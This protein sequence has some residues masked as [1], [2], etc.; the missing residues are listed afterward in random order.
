MSSYADAAKVL[1]MTPAAV[2]QQVR[3]L[4]QFFE[5]KLLQKHGRGVLLTDH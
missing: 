4:E 1:N 2:S 3:R 5:I